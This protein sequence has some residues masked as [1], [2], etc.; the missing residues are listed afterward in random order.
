[1]PGLDVAA[2]HV[3]HAIVQLALGLHG[4]HVLLINVGETDHKDEQD[5]KRAGVSYCST[6]WRIRMPQYGGDKAVL[7]YPISEMSAKFLV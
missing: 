4:V 3:L 6:L 1:M 2:A 5:G 7:W